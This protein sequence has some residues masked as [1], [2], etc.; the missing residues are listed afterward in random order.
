MEPY[1]ELIARA[2]ACVEKIDSNDN[3]DMES[4]ASECAFMNAALQL[5]TECGDSASAVA[6]ATEW[7]ENCEE[8]LTRVEEENED[9]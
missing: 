3:I 5:L 2:N 9:E 7:I 8:W 4:S 6:K 1:E